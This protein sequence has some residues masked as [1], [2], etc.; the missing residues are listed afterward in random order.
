MLTGYIQNNVILLSGLLGMLSSAKLR[1]GLS[2]T[3]V[4][5]TLSARLLDS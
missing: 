2:S 5:V 4:L 3:N 1:L